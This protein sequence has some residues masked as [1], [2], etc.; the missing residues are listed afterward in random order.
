MLGIH[1]NISLLQGKLFSLRAIN[2]IWRKLT[3]AS[4]KKPPVAS[5]TGGRMN[6]G[7]FTVSEAESFCTSGRWYQPPRAPSPARLPDPYG[8]LVMRARG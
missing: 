6:I 3:F 4:M 1:L 8:S 7:D 2:V 5:A